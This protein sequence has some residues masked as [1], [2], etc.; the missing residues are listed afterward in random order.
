VFSNE[1]DCDVKALEPGGAVDL[2]DH[3]GAFLGRGYANPA[4]LIAVRL[5]ARRKEDIDSQIFWTIKL[6]AALNY[7]MAACPGR[8]SLRLVHAEADGLPGLIVDRYG[9][10][11]A[12]QLSALGTEHRKDLIAGALREVFEPAGAVLRSTGRARMREGLEEEVAPWF[13]PTPPDEVVIDENGVQYGVQLL[14]GQKTGHFFDQ[15]ENRAFAGSLCKGRR[16]LD[17][18]AHAGGWAIAALLAGAAEATV[19]DKSAH[20]IELAK[21]NAE[22]NGVAD[23]LTTICGEGRKTLQGMLQ[24]SEQFDAVVLD[25]PAFAKTRKAAGSALRGYQEINALGASLLSQGGLL[26]TSTCSHHVLEDRYLDAV[27]A[28][29]RQADRWMRVIRRSGAAADHPVRPEVPETT[30]LKSYAL[31]TELNR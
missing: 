16:V 20:A 6:R 9:D 31:Y 30:Y 1:L 15:A 2:T 25:P 19:V 26:F 8:T 10:W 17:V 12:V 22:L 11:L 5:L 24:R 7:R 18:Y 27:R 4:S 21:R 13:G 23:R 29:V 3:K 14:A 28:G